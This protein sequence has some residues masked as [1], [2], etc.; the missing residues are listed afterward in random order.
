V[1]RQFFFLTAASYSGAALSVWLLSGFIPWFLLPDVPFMAI[2]YSGLF[3]PGPAGFLTALPCA[4]FRELSASAPP[5]SFFLASMALYFAS[6]EIGLRLFIHTEPFVLA[7]VSGLLAAESLSLLALTA[8]DGGRP[9]SLLWGA[10]E[11]VR[12][13]WTSLLAVPVFMD[14]PMRWQRVRE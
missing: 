11:A 5:W 10:E 1:I 6:R 3:M 13:A 9:L 14:M 8:L 7:T 4:L 12:I 2:V